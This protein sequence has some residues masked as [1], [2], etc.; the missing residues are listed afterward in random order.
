M[1]LSLIS[2]KQDLKGDVER[3]L[4]YPKKA[5][6]SITLGRNFFNGNNLEKVIDPDTYEIKNDLDFINFLFEKFNDRI[7]LSGE[8]KVGKK[9]KRNAGRIELE[10]I[11]DVTFRIVHKNELFKES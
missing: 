11:N 7:F 10:K 1:P 9:L 8:L 5:I 4:F 3:K 6:K 2:P